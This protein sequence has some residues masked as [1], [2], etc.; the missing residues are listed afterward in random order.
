M[1]TGRAAGGATARSREGERC[2]DRLGG[3]EA[4]PVAVAAEVVGDLPEPVLEV[5]GAD[6]VGERQA[7]VELA[8]AAEDDGG[9][10]LDGVG[11]DGEA[12]GA[13]EHGAGV[14]DGTEIVGQER[15]GGA[16]ITVEAGDAG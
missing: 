5:F 1:I 3:G 6:V 7:V 11:V 4:T 16:E 2:G 12:I 13:A 10:G 8:E 14:V 15:A 9:V